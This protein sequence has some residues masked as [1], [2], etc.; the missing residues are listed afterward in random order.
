MATISTG[1]L[2][3]L[4]DNI[5]KSLVDLEAALIT[6][7][8]GGSPSKAT[9]QNGQNA[10]SN[11]LLSHVA[12]L[13]DPDQEA[14]LID[15]AIADAAK[16]AATV[17]FSMNGFRRNYAEFL[18]AL[19]RHVGGLNAFLVTNTLQVHPYFA[20]CFNYIADLAPQLGLASAALTHVA[21]SRIFTPTEVILG[22]I[23]VTGAAAGTFSAGTAL[24][25]SL[26]GASQLYLKNTAGAPTTGTNT[27]FGITYTNAAGTSG[28]TTTQA[29]SGALGAGAYLAVGAITG[30]AVSNIT[31]NSNGA[32]TDAIA[33][34]VK[35]ARTIAY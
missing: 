3:A 2:T 33:V 23:A 13:A 35:P 28:Q 20:A 29:L 6:N 26:Y 11:S 9:I 19:D 16:V 25:T 5:A 21:V 32:N 27:V 24:N 17:D 4:A 12:G 1:N 14:A 8:V 31:V 10:G 22:S 30:S 7:V 15:E 34:V 18:I